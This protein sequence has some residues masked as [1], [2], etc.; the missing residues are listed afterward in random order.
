MSGIAE[1]L[2]ILGHKYMSSAIEFLS[3]LLGHFNERGSSISNSC[4][5]SFIYVFEY[6]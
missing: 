6:V 3:K 1:F 2:Q 5:I 4:S